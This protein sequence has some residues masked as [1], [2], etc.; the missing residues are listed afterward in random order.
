MQLH[1]HLLEHI[2]E[3]VFAARQDSADG[4]PG[5][6]LANPGHA[7]HGSDVDRLRLG[8]G[9]GPDDGEHLPQ[10]PALHDLPEQRVRVGLVVHPATQPGAQPA[11]AGVL[12]MAHYVEAKA[13]ELV[14][15]LPVALRR[16][17]RGVARL[18]PV[19]EN[20]L[21]ALAAGVEVEKLDFWKRALHVLPDL[22]QELLVGLSLQERVVRVARQRVANRGVGGLHVLLE[23]VPLL[24][25]RVSISVGRQLLRPPL[26]L[27]ARHEAE[28]LHPEQ[29]AQGL[30]RGLWQCIH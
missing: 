27:G 10:A 17:G 1:I 12:P 22:L 2:V 26:R 25:G 24:Q 9:L 19:V 4:L 11:H 6:P 8:R 28:Q 18:A 29:P 14:H 23:P 16:V 5:G 20:L 15:A 7:R 13:R 21:Y 30:R 3:N